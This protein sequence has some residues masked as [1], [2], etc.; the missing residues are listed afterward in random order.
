MESLSEEERRSLRVLGV[1]G[2]RGGSDGGNREEEGNGEGA[3]YSREEGSMCGPNPKS[4]RREWAPSM[5]PLSYLPTPGVVPQR[6]VPT[7]MGRR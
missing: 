7:R 3:V 6:V 4:R 1:D 2:G 5:S